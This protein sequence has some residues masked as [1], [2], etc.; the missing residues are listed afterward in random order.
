VNE[1]FVQRM[2]EL[3]QRPNLARPIPEPL[4][5]IWEGAEPE[6]FC[7]D[8]NYLR[9]FAWTCGTNLLLVQDAEWGEIRSGIHGRIIQ[10]MNSD[11]NDRLMELVS[12][13]DSVAVVGLCETLGELF[14]QAGKFDNLEYGTAL[15]KGKPL[16]RWEWV[17][18]NVACTSLLDPDPFSVQGAESNE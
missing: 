16:P 17:D 13:A 18:A 4:H 1:R 9:V 15:P 11:G 7:D 8:N 12:N 14:W 5:F 2:R 6:R 10:V 3:A